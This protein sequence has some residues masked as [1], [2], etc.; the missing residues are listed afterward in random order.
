ME[1]GEL[2]DA[3]G[4]R[5]SL[6]N[7]IIVMTSNIGSEI[8]GD[9]LGF[10]PAGRAEETEGALRQAFSPEFLGRLDR[11]IHFNALTPEAENAIAGKYLSQLQKRAR[12]MGVSLRFSADL[13]EYFARRCRRQGGARQLRSLIQQE[14][15]APLATL[16]L[17]QYAKP[18][19]ICVEVKNER[20]FLNT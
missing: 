3:T 6:K 1:E 16:L 14:L 13:Q 19:T 15:E 7:A 20:I 18:E 8:K 5:V 9:G 10:H 2:T 4:R 12:N 17:Q 11:V